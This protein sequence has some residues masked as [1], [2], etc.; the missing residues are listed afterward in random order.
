MNAPGIQ[1][2]KAAPL[3]SVQAEPKTEQDAISKIAQN[4]GP[5]ASGNLASKAPKIYS[6]ATG[7]LSLA[8][9]I[10][11]DESD[12][13]TF[14]GGLNKVAVSVYRQLIRWKMTTRQALLS[15]LAKEIA[16]NMRIKTKENLKYADFSRISPE[17]LEWFSREVKK[18]ARKEGKDEMFA[19]R[20]SAY[21][22]SCHEIWKRAYGKEKKSPITAFQISY[23][24][25]RDYFADRPL[26]QEDKLMK[27]FPKSVPIDHEAV[28]SK[29][30]EFKQQSVKLKTGTRID[31]CS[32]PGFKEIQEDRFGYR[33]L[34][35]GK[36][37]TADLVGVFDGHGGVKSVDFVSGALPSHLEKQL[38]DVNVLDDKKVQKAIE[39]AFESASNVPIGYDSGTTA[40]V[41][42]RIGNRLF[43]AHLGDSRA[44]LFRKNGQVLQLSR[45]Q[46]PNDPELMKR[47]VVVIDD[48]IFGQLETGGGFGDLNIFGIIRRPEISVVTLQG[49]EVL[50]LCSSG[51]DQLTEEETRENNPLQRVMKAVQT[52]GGNATDLQVFFG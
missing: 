51:F 50:R 14:K 41:S 36:N 15:S 17:K 8:G 29:S 21:Q 42:I 34:N 47:G 7:N 33:V 23:V 9:R 30:A 3:P 13:P 52:K 38:Q 46:R 19:S 18:M 5:Q 35:L 40:T 10:I 45:D 11:S 28:P 26:R 31:Y 16:E 24:F 1:P 27:G 25:W 12:K 2:D 4:I 37:Q 22:D 39:R 48:K 43:T 44:Q 32:S 49:G 20:G 6:E